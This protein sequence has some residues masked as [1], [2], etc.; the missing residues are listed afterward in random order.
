MLG[1]VTPSMSCFQEEIF[2]PVV[3]VSAFR[4]EEH[5]LDLANDSAYGLVSTRTC[6]PP[7]RQTQTMALLVL[8]L[9]PLYLV[10]G[11]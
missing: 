9:C 11:L 8:Q 6:Q 3:S 10:C 1:S 2:G 7:L 5:A 4:D